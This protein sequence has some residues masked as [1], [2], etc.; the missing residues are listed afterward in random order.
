MEIVDQKKNQK[1]QFEPR[2]KKS[3]LALVGIYNV[4]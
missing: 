3:K 1:G 2:F 4:D